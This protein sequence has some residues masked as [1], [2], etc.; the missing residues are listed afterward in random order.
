MSPSPTLSPS[1][2]PSAIPSVKVTLKNSEEYTILKGSICKYKIVD[3][4]G[5]APDEEETN[6]R[7]EDEDKDKDEDG[8]KIG[9]EGILQ[10]IKEYWQA[11]VSGV[12]IILIIAFL[13][14][15][16]SYEGRRKK[17]NKSA[18]ERYKSYY[19][20]AIGLFGW[21][22]TSWTAIACVMIVLTV[23]SLVIM[24]IAKSRCGKAE[25]ELAYKK[26]EYDRNQRD[27]NMKM[28]FMHMMGGQGNMQGQPQGVYM[29]SQ[30]YVPTAFL[31]FHRLHCLPLL[32]AR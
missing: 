3:E 11:I 31:W 7:E 9:I 14:K 25:D 2:K 22:A 13:A 26:E 23:A 21:A 27:E 18:E 17:A 5:Y 4:N 24:L 19:A 28:M 1:A 10:A 6:N 12:C 15:T 32:H 30:R 16:A 29:N 20:G 8:D